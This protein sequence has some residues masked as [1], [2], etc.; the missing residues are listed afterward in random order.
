MIPIDEPTWFEEDVVV[1]IHDRQLAE[2]GGTEGIRDHGMLESALARP[3][4]LWSYANPDLYDLAAAYAF[5]L[6]KNRPLL[7]GNKRIAAVMC[8]TL[9]DLFDREI[10]LSQAEKYVHYYGLAAGD[11]TEDAFANW[12]RENSGPLEE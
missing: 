12:L 8:E 7:D 1:A 5:G 3:K 6:A 9:L 11:E 4:Q 10:Q 2:H